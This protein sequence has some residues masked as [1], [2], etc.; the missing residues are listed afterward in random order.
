MDSVGRRLIAIAVCGSIM[1]AILAAS[2]FSVENSPAQAGVL[3]LRG[4]D[5]SKESLNLDGE[6]EFYWGKLVSYTELEGLSPDLYSAVPSTWESYEIDGR[7]LPSRGY[8][9]YRL[10]VVTDLEPGTKLGLQIRSFSSAYNVYINDI[11]VANNGVVSSVRG[12]YHPKYRPQVTEF[13]IPDYEFDIIIQ[14][15]NY[16]HA[17]GGFWYSIVLGSGEGITRLGYSMINRQVVYT[18]ALLLLAFVYFC[19][20]AL[21]RQVKEYLY[22]ALHVFVV[23]ILVDSLNQFMIMNLWPGLGFRWQLFLWYG[24]VTWTVALMALVVETL[25]PVRYSKQVI[26]GIVICTCLVTL[27]YAFAPVYWYTH[28]LIP[29]NVFGLLILLFVLFLLIQAVRRGREGSLLYTAGFI[30]SINVFIVET[31]F[32]NNFL[33]SSGQLLYFGLGVLLFTQTLVLAIRAAR[34]FSENAVLLERL[35]LVNQQREEFMINTSHQIRAP[36]SAIQ[37]ITEELLKSREQLS[38]AQQ[39][40]LTQIELLGGKVASLVKDIMDYSVLARGEM[41]LNLEPVNL[42]TVVE[43]LVQV[44][45]QANPEK[46]ISCLVPGNLPP[47]SADE[48]RVYQILYNLLGYVLKQKGQVLISAQTEADFVEVFVT[49]TQALVTNSDELFEDGDLALSITRQ[50]IVLQGGSIRAEGMEPGLTLRFTLPRSDGD[51]GEGAEFSLLPLRGQVHIPGEGPHILVVDD[52]YTTLNGTAGILAHSGYAVTAVVDGKMALEKLRADKSIAVVLMDSLL[53]GQSGYDICREIRKTKSM[54]DLPVLLMT[55]KSGSRN[56]GLGFEAGANDCLVKPYEREEL[57][58][59]VQTLV[60]LKESVD[61]AINSEIAFLQAQ[62][63]PHFLF[64]SLSVI[65]AL[66]TNQPQRAKELILSLGGYLQNSF[67]FSGVEDM[68]PLAREIELVEA[69]VTLEEARFGSRLDFGIEMD[70]L[71]TQEIHLPRL[72]LQ[73]LVE[74]AIGHG[75]FNK[76]EGGKVRVW[77]KRVE[78][79]ICFTV[80]DDGVGMESDVV[81]NLFT[82]TARQGVGLANINKRLLRYYGAGLKVQSKPGQG[83]TVSFNI[84][85]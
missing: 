51:A 4:W 82:S 60:S 20:Y 53:P 84:P 37:T 35:Q 23:V 83:T 75:L 76:P 7:K 38:A 34:T 21:R 16:H 25:F 1:V 56:I 12:T 81:D 26:R 27:I 11:P 18:G 40:Q 85:E 78:A 17:R 70:E 22:V 14:V 63:K 74:N 43:N 36:L 80:W 73:P 66:A 42:K 2:F 45:G 47:V 64:N 50:L 72:A 5:I 31:L 29:L 48:D 58:A 44:L 57:L 65:A 10:R 68:M 24:S 54:F 55:A 30:T 3:D 6:W 69:Y 71:D 79:G 8:G 41:P 77:I 28:F 59:R 52:N 32:A 62:I 49:N 39:G 46:A 33:D 61:K 13:A 9:T 15:A 67:D 19:W